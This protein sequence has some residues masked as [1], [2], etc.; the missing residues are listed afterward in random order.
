[1]SVELPYA[2]SRMNRCAQRSFALN[3]EDQRVVSPD[4]FKAF[5]KKVLN[6]MKG[7][8]KERPRSESA[9]HFYAT[10]IF[11]L[12]RHDTRCICVP[13]ENSSLAFILVCFDSRLVSIRR[14]YES[15]IIEHS[16]STVPCGALKTDE[17]Y[18]FR[19]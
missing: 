1:M 7:R 11:S 10:A 16:E 2:A 9:W 19:I 17:V 4:S 12:S 6:I 14:R 8:I 18:C 13:K 3:G 15:K 5:A